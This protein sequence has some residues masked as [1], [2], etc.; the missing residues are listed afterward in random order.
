MRAVRDY[1][2]RSS[3]SGYPGLALDVRAKPAL[4]QGVDALIW[5]PLPAV[6]AAVESRF[7]RYCVV[8]LT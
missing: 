6:D 8:E 7:G 5:D 2:E 3:V 1:G 4:R